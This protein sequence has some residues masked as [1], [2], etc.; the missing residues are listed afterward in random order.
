MAADPKQKHVQFT[1]EHMATAF[2]LLLEEYESW[3]K[4]YTRAG[5]TPPPV[6]QLQAYKPNN[7]EANMV[8]IKYTTSLIEKMRKDLMHLEQ[9]VC[10]APHAEIVLNMLIG[11]GI[12]RETLDR[13]INSTL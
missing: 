11:V 2:G 5:K 4:R 1:E 10:S 8:S 13:K 7:F 3:S 6:S 12:S 9:S